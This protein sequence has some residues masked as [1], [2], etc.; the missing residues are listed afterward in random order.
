MIA[1]LSQGMVVETGKH[2]ELI[3]RRGVYYALV[4]AQKGQGR[5]GSGGIRKSSKRYSAAGISTALGPASSTI[6]V[7]PDDIIT[8]QEV[9]FKYPCRPEQEVFQGLKLSVKKGENLSI[10]GPR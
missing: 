2:S 8:F 10:V 1:V 3:S 4:E 6:S 5:E 9:G 7:D